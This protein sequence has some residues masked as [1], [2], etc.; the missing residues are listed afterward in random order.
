MNTPY[1]F[2]CYTNWTTH[3]HCTV[4]WKCHHDNSWVKLSELGLVKNRAV[5]A[6][7]KFW[8]STPFKIFIPINIL[9]IIFSKQDKTVGFLFCW[10]FKSHPYDPDFREE[11]KSNA[12]RSYI[13]SSTAL[14]NPF[15]KAGSQ[16]LEPDKF[17]K[18]QFWWAVCVCVHVWGSVNGCVPDRT[19][20]KS[21]LVLCS[22]SVLS[23]LSDMI[24]LNGLLEG[25]WNIG[26]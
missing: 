15:S 25:F 10:P 9:Y 22:V 20:L 3:S 1:A 14:H 11:D 24:Q 13:E 21:D 19:G 5:F 26:W 12:V 8:E 6:P 23:T 7:K 16:S 2:R 17:R 18:M 4:Q